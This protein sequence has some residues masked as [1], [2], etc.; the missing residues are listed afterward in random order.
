MR[1]DH[2]RFLEKLLNTPSP[3][4]FEQPAQRVVRTRMA[5]KADTID[6][7]IH[8]NLICA[9]NPDGKPRVMLAAHV[10]QIG[11]MVTHVDEQGF[12][13][14]RAIGGLDPALLPGS[15]VSVHTRKGATS[16]VIGHCPERLRGP[17]QKDSKS[18][19]RDLAFRD[20]AIDIGAKSRSDAMRKLAIGDTVTFALGA[21]MLGD[22]LLTGPGLD[23]K[24]GIAVITE[25]ARK[26][27]RQRPN[28]A[29]FAVS[30]VQEEIGS[31]GAMTAAYAIKPDVAI[32]VDVTDAV[33]VPDVDRRTAGEVSLG[34][35]PSIVVGAN[36]NAR[37]G[38][39]LRSAA[40]AKKIPV[41]PEAQP[42][43]SPSDADALQISRAGIAIGI[44]GIPCRY[45]HT[46]VETVDLKDVDRATDLLVEFCRK[47][48][49]GSSFHPR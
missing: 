9:I 40:R 36:A 6:A 29:I 22:R 25:A 38:E 26:L 41:Q 11:L 23:N 30:T 24:A 15:R 47:L 19:F 37:V 48:R 34:H 3:S 7:D 33:D 5:E 4:G 35:G 20:L 49:P 8:G 32:C 42:E 18:S 17:T 39:L 14:A 13:F 46:A 2:L 16:G 45:M 1:P 21:E 44:V 12:A 43:C 31:R 27:S 10:D 28:C